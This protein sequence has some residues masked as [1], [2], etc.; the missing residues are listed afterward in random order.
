MFNSK[1]YATVNCLRALGL[2]AI[3]RA[4]SGH[5]GI[6]LSAAPIIYTLFK[7][8]LKIAP[9]NPKFFNRDR[10]VLSAGHGSALLY[11]TLMCAGYSEI[12]M[13]DL[14]NFR[15]LNSK[16]AGH[17][18][19]SLLS[20]I[21][22]PSGPLGQGLAQAVGMAIAEKKLSAMFNR[23][24]HIVDHYTYCLVGDGCLEEGIAYESMAIAGKLKL[25]KLI[26]LYD[27]NKIQLDGKVS[28]SSN[29]N[30]KEFAKSLN[31]NYIYVS[32]GNNI[33]S[34]NFAISRAKLSF[35]PTLIEVNTIIGYGSLK[36]GSNTCHGAPFSNDEV[37]KIKKTLKYN[38]KPFTIPDFVR[39]D[40]TTP[41]NN[42]GQKAVIN[43][44]AKLCKLERKDIK[45]Y[46]QLT[47]MMKN[48]YTIDINWFKDFEVNQKE[49]TRNLC[50]RVL[51]V[52][53]KKIPGLLLGS[54][55]VCA[56]TKVGGSIYK[57]LNKNFAIGQN[58]NY[59][60]REMAMGAIIN[61]INLHGGIKAIASTFLVFS[62]YVKPTIRL[63]AI[64]E[65][66]SINIFSHDS[67]T[68]GEDGPTHQPIEQINSLRMIPN[69]YVFRPCNFVEMIT[70]LNYGLSSTSTPIS[71]ITS[72]GEFEQLNNNESYTE[73]LQGGYVIKNNSNYNLTLLASGSEVAIAKDVGELLAKHK[74]IARIVS[75]PCFKLFMNQ[76]EKYRN[77]ILGNKPV[78]SIEYGSTYLWESIADLCFGINSFGKSGNTKSVVKYFGLDANSISEKIVK[79][80]KSKKRK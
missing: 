14:M 24:N 38:V 40:F 74:I 1:K 37:A 25:N 17:P 71:I 75:V 32:D 2:E 46:Y 78:I 65:V 80:L 3:A 30:I 44:N 48:Q 72:R 16:T 8:H 4:N 41:I 10:F 36:T 60:V 26:V 43:F 58:V 18:E 66:P 31:W 69:H 56:S 35:K 13:N 45:L 62:D 67:I 63:A 49:A 73:V 79:F 52:V 59:G 61:G 27:S 9:N 21:D 54:A 42:R 55:D 11:A 53:A 15:A 22:A 7:N 51:S 12:K 47:S 29:V 68:V 57:D 5:P 64:G 50:G 6:V 33:S 77:K 34:I 20:C 28:D 23:F 19:T 76:D 39:D 70:A